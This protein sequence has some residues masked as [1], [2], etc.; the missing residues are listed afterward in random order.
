[1]HTN[2]KVD[3]KSNGIIVFAIIY[4]ENGKYKNMTRYMT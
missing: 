2:T 3:G 1:M 4:G